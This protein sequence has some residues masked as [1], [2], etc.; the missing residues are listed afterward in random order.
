V[1]GSTKYG[2]GV[3][4]KTAKALGLTLSH[5]LLPR[6]DA[7]IEQV[8]HSCCEVHGSAIG[9]LSPCWAWHRMVRY[10]AQIDLVTGVGPKHKSP[11]G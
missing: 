4:L 2:L 7:I 8:L 1:Q 6:A 5:T 9:D 11:A 3:N 10:S